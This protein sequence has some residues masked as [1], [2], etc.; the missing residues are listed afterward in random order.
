MPMILESSAADAT[1]RFKDSGVTVCKMMRQ[2]CSF[3][4]GRRGNHRISIHGE[5][6]LVKC[7]VYTNNVPHLMI[8]LE[9]QRR[10]GS[11]EVDT[12]QIVHKENLTISFTTITRLRALRGFANFDDDHV[13]AEESATSQ[14][15]AT[16]TTYGTTW[17]S[18]SYKP[19]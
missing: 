11:I 15:N 17:P 4:G 18:N 16:E 9:L 6:V 7:R 10:H 14:A 13:A 1:N 5:D 8:Y 12:V 19:E 3:K 2:Y